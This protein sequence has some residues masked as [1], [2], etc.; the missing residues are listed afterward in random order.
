MNVYLFQ[1]RELF[2]V[3]KKCQTQIDVQLQLEKKGR[4]GSTNRGLTRG[5]VTRGS[6]GRFAQG[7][8]ANTEDQHEQ[9]GQSAQPSKKSARAR[10]FPFACRLPEESS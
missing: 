3:T 5:P 8:Q 1:H 10:S 7:P 6:R 4:R 9:F 2:I